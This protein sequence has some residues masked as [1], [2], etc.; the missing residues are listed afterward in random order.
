MEE[1]EARAE[2]KV[3]RA[4]H[5]AAKDLEQSSPN[6][7]SYCHLKEVAR[8][9]HREPKVDKGLHRESR[10][11]SAEVADTL[12]ATVSLRWNCALAAIVV[13]RGT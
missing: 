13:S 1:K 10:A 9:A 12:P 8:V 4:S 3:K 5:A 6:C 11:I 2:E 7:F